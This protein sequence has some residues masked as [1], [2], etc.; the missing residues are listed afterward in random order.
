MFFRGTG[1]E[2]TG[3]STADNMSVILQDLPKGS[4]VNHIPF[5]IPLV[6]LPRGFTHLPTFQQ[7]NISI[8]IDTTQEYHSQV[9]D[10]KLRDGSVRGQ[11][12]P[13]FVPFG[14]P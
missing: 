8:K 5:P 4:Q 7:Q 1:S 14:D 11:S 2:A 6:M 3:R 13:S 10:Q 12:R 9:G